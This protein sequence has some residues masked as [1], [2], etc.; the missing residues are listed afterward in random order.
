VTETPAPIA[1]IAQDASQDAQ[2]PEEPRVYTVPEY[3]L[4][5]LTEKVASLAKRA[6][7]LGVPEPKLITIKHWVREDP[8]YDH[9]TLEG[10][11]RIRKTPVV[12]VRVEGEAPKLPGGW[13]LTAV[14]QHTD[15]GNLVRT[16]PGR[17]G[18]LPLR[19]RDASPD[20]CDHCHQRRRR[21]DTYVVDKDGVFVQVG[22][23]CIKDF[24]G[25]TNPERLAQWA[26]IVETVRQSL[27]DEEA[28]GRS[29]GAPDAYALDDV[30]ALAAGVTRRFGWVSKKAVQMAIE[31]GEPFG[32]TT[33]ERVRAHLDP[34]WVERARRYHPDQVAEPDYDLGDATIDYWRAYFAGKPAD[35]WSDFDNN[36]HTVLSASHLDDRMIGYAAYL[37]AGFLKAREREAS[38]EAERRLQ[39]GLA[40]TSEHQGKVGERLALKL[41]VTFVKYL[42]GAYGATMLT[43]LTDDAGNAFVW[44]ASKEYKPGDVLVGKAT[45]KAHTERQGVKETQ[46]TRGSFT[47]A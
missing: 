35:R 33:A 7:R 40:Q 45:V 9:Q 42:E 8:D 28:Y 22:S 17:E 14:L 44:F 2:A 43:K 10:R 30:T 18:D 13:A 32:R 4:E 16:V 5:W 41:T 20:D 12:D 37:P 36:M 38:R 31:A 26:A 1:L 21:N 19:F 47:V 46:I 6:T 15:G 3:H 23:T 11:P 24:L 34:K 29:A 25:H 27:A 39:G